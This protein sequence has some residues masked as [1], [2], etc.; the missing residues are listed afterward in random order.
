MRAWPAVVAV[1]AVV[2]LAATARAQTRLTIAPAVSV[3]AGW[4]DNLFLDPTLTSAT[5]PRA[6]AIIDVAPSLAAA[7]VRQGHE[8]ALDVDYLERITPSNGDLRDVTARL[9]WSSPAWHRLRFGLAARYEHYD[10]TE[11]VDNT[12]DLGGGDAS[13]RL[14]LGRGWLQLAYGADARGYSDP[15]RNGQLDVDQLAAATGGVRLARGLWLALGYRFLDV[16]SDEPTA[17]LQRHRGDVGLSWQPA[18]WLSASAGYGVWL[19]EL[20]NGAVPLSSMVPGGPR[21]DVAHAVSVGVDVRV[22]AWLQLFARY[23]FLLSTS[24][25]ANGR[26][27]LDRVVAGLSLGWIWA[28]TTAP[29]PPS[30]APVVRGREVTFRARARP[31][32]R[33]AVVGDWAD[34]Q[35]APLAP[36]GGDR[37]EATLTLPP[38]RHAWALM[39]DGAVV[40]PPQAA[41]FVDDGFGGKNA[42]VEV[43]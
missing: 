31:G 18:A 8:L 20:P 39:I 21:Q 14:A 9:G 29:P 3:A 24:D 32:A 43:P 4:D 12:F 17:V 42:I 22:R 36:A 27:R 25:D 23:D 33:V 37:Y 10:A 16:R 41:G 15:S 2:G 5:P 11:F 38:G 19:Q 6:D 40:T 7:L 1:G 35:P 13:L 28:R 34:W 30:L 26:Y